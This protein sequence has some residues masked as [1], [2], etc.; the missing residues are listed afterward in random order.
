MRRKPI[1]AAI[2]AD[3]H[4]RRKRAENNRN[5]AETT[6]DIF[7]NVCYNDIYESHGNKRFRLSQP[8]TPKNK[9]FGRA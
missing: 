4:A 5:Q 2:R 8:E 9:P 1:C 6:I 3:T 7:D